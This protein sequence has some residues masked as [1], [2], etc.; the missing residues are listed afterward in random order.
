MSD[1]S[2]KLKESDFQKP[3]LLLKFSS[4]VADLHKNNYC[5]VSESSLSKI[6]Y[7]ICSFIEVF[8]IFMSSSP[9]HNIILY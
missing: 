1:K 2:G 9:Q 5:D 6:V 8:V 4:I 7:Q 3:L